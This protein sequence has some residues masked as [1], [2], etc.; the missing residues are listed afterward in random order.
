MVGKFGL[1]RPGSGDFRGVCDNVVLTPTDSVIVAAAKQ[2]VGKV[3]VTVVFDA[4][5]LFLWHLHLRC[6]C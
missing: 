6:C 4:A 1:P 3:F 2:V 5:V